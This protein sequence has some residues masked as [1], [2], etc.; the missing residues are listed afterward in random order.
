MYNIKLRR[1]EKQYRIV[2]LKKSTVVIE[3]RTKV[4]VMIRDE[5]DKVRLEQDEIK[6]KR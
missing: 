3:G 5:T 6:R 4:I 1:D 2:V